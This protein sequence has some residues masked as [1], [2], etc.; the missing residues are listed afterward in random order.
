MPVRA[1]CGRSAEISAGGAGNLYLLP[2]R[3][4][5]ARS[6]GSGDADIG[7]LKR[8][9]FSSNRH[10]ALAYCWSMIFPK[11]GA[12][13]SGSCSNLADAT[14]P[15][16]ASASR[17]GRPG[18]AAGRLRP[19]LRLGLQLGD[20]LAIEADE[21]HRI[22]TQGRE[23]A[24]HDGVRDD[25]AREREQQA[26]A[27]DHH[28]RMQVL[29]RDVLHAED[30]GVEHL[31]LEQDHAGAFRLALDL[32]LDLDVVLGH[33]F[34]ADVDLNVDGRLLLA[35]LQRARRIGIL[36]RQILDVLGQDIELRR[37]SL[38]A[39]SLG[40][41]RGR[42][43]VGGHRHKV[44]SGGSTALGWLADRKST[45]LNSSHLGIS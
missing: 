31:E 24:V 29:L 23:A 45:R 41:A 39:T 35:G 25:L 43:A 12:H 15:S 7:S 34:G 14:R 44:S 26:R 32:E 10:L 30:A 36:E 19:L 33:W 3:L 1:G 28:D 4:S 5:E 20:A 13:F 9:D 38:L 11:T 6:A 22:D 8:D 40:A 18:I 42:S 27:L 2:D 21:I 17:S 16:R 37:R